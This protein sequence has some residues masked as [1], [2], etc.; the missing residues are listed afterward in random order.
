MSKYEGIPDNITL[1]FIEQWVRP[2]NSEKRF[3]HIK[4]V[5]DVASKISKKVGCD[6]FLAEL[7]G[8]LHDACKEFKEKELVE[9]ARQYGLPLDGILERNGHLLHGP[10]AAEIAKRELNITNG[11]VYDAVYQHTL[12]AVPMRDLS[13]VL[14]LADCLEESRPTDYTDPIWNALNL[15]G[16]VDMDAAIVVASDLG[17]QH[18]IES[19][20]PIHP[21]TVEVRNYYLDLLR[22]KSGAH[23]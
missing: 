3:K 16:A 11:E 15:K 13:K 19:K 12:G 8:W 23:T 7:S 18:L 20:K 5:V 4:G 22:T 21:L 14:F 2:R 17:L 10:V 6:V 1:E 9:L